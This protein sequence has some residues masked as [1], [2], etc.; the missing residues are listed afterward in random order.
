MLPNLPRSW[1]VESSRSLRERAIDCSARVLAS[2]KLPWAVSAG[3]SEY[4]PA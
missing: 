3:G 2:G 4:A 1:V